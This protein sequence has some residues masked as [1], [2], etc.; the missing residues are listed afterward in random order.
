[1]INGHSNS[2]A[3]DLSSSEGKKFNM[4][5][6]MECVAEEVERL[7]GERSCILQH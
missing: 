4:Q 6:T 2:E 3:K 1:V 5:M 7:V